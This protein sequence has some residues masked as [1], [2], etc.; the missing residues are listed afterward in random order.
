VW[1]S[2]CHISK[3]KWMCK[4]Q[5]TAWRV[6]LRMHTE[7]HGCL[8][9]LQ[10]AAQLGFLMPRANNYNGCPKEITSCIKNHI[11]DWIFFNLF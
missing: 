6:K 1:K 11:I 9:Y 4:L 5:D 3:L 10:P 7:L 2:E 8:E